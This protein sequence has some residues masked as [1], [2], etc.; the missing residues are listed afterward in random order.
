VTTSFKTIERVSE[1]VGAEVARELH[2][3][4]AQAHARSEAAEN[5]AELLVVQGDGMRIRELVPAEPD[6]ADASADAA[7]QNASDELSD[8]ERAAGW[9]RT[10][11]RTFSDAID[12]GECKVGVVARSIPGRVKPDG[13]YEHPK[14]LVQTYVATMADVRPHL[15]RRH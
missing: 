4:F 15:L 7:L 5:P 8:D 14:T 11:V 3:P 10:F 13:E 12:G 6:T 1:Q 2:G 9:K